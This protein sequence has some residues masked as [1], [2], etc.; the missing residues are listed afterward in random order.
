VFKRVV[1]FG[2]FVSSFPRKVIG[3]V[4]LWIWECLGLFLTPGK[5][6]QKK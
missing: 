3:A 2:L 1:K 5:G 4:V 6:R